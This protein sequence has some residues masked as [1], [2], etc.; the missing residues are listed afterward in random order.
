MVLY[1]TYTFCPNGCH[2]N[3]KAYFAK[4]IKK[5]TPQKLYGGMKLK[6]SRNFHSISFYKIIVFLLLLHMH[7]GCNGSLEFP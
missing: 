1:Q 3:Q 5:S 6:L 7:F 2:G 4:N